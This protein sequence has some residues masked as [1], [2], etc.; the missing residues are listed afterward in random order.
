MQEI[1]L[2]YTR[3][4]SE[5]IYYLDTAFS[6]GL[7]GVDEQYLKTNGY[8]LCYGRTFL[9]ED[10]ANYRS[11][12][13]LDTKAVTALFGGQNPVGQTI[14][15]RRQ[16]FT[17]VGVVDQ[18]V[19]VEPNIQSMMDYQ[20]Y[21]DTSSGAVFIPSAA[22]PIVYRFD[23]PQAVCVQAASTDEMTTAGKNVADYLTGSFG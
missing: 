9:P 18:R 21:A 2:Y 10:Y 15:I 23:E 11:V 4:Y 5:D 14:E 7:Y 8:Q 12:A 17:I 20:L 16:P 6:G 22:W 1:S 3:S 13:V 19:T